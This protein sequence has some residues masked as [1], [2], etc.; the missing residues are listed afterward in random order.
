MNFSQTNSIFPP[1]MRI[2]A[3][4]TTPF[5]GYKTPMAKQIIFC[6]VIDYQMFMLKY[7]LNILP[8]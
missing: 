4:Q 7:F 5:E 3:K 8:R 6:L 1:K 2:L